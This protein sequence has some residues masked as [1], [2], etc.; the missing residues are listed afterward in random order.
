M[1]ALRSFLLL[2]VI[3]FACASLLQRGLMLRGFAHLKAAVAESVI[4]LVLAVGLT[5]AVYRPAHARAAALATQGLA[6]LGVAVG[7]ATIIIGI[8]PR[9]ALDYVIHAVMALVLVGGLLVA[10]AQGARI[11]P[12]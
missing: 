1:T 2:E 3:I 11:S 10:R 5:I 6:L 7:V 8:G 9:T 4:G 12:T